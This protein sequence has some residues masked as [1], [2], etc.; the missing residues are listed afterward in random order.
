MAS[1]AGIN[2]I[3]LSRTSLDVAFDDNGQQV[4]ALTGSP[5]EIVAGMMTLF[6]RYGGQGMSPEDALI[7]YIEAM[8]ALRK[9]QAESFDFG[10]P[11]ARC[12]W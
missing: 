11:D 2:G 9:G 3:Y 5:P 6:N 7:K 4:N 10:H 8:C 1:G 12:V